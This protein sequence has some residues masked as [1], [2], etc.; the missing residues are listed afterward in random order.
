[1]S[2]SPAQMFLQA[3]N[4]ESFAPPRHSPPASVPTAASAA[5]SPAESPVPAP[6][7]SSSPQL[8][9][10][11]RVDNRHQVYYEF[12]DDCTG[13]VLCEIPPEALRAIG[14]SLNVPL[15][16]DGSAHSIDVKS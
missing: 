3:A 5:A 1:M 7:V 10:D 15:D 16:G 13:D 11:M 9:T 14:E 8:S 4:A 12:V 6:P 2:I